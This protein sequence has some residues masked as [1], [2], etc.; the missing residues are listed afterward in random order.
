MQKNSLNLKEIFKKGLSFSIA[1]ALSAAAT[2]LNLAKTANADVPTITAATV[3]SVYVEGEKPSYV[4]VKVGASDAKSGNCHVYGSGVSTDTTDVAVLTTDRTSIW[5]ADDAKKEDRIEQKISVKTWDAVH[6]TTPEKEV[7]AGTTISTYLKAN[8][9]FLQNDLVGSVD[10]LTKMTTDLAG[11]DL[12]IGDAA[13]AKAATAT[14][15]DHNGKTVKIKMNGDASKIYDVCTLKVYENP[16][17]LR[18]DKP[19][20]L[21]WVADA[22]DSAYDFP[23]FVIE[24]KKDDKDARKIA[25]NDST[26]GNFKFAMRNVGETTTKL[27]TFTALPTFEKKSKEFKIQYTDP[28]TGAVLTSSDEQLLHYWYVET[29]SITDIDPAKIT[30][31]MSDNFKYSVVDLA[32]NSDV[33]KK[34]KSTLKSGAEIIYAN[35]ISALSGI[36]SG[37]ATVGLKVGKE[38]KNQQVTVTKLANDD[39]G[40]MSNFVKTV[41]SDGF[42]TIKT[43]D[44]GH[45][46][47]SLGVNAVAEESKEDNKQA[48]E[49]KSAEEAKKAEE[50]KKAEENKSA[51]SSKSASSSSKSASSSAKTGDNSIVMFSA[52]GFV[53]LI[54]AL[55]LFMMKKN[56]KSF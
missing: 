52:F 40:K 4:G 13:L 6:P 30:A 23:D 38:Y 12:M 47:V 41:D 34:I 56:R 45:F 2:S 55:A 18:V 24:I 29:K 37:K 20:G 27:A 7:A 48:E 33:Y 22:G 46:V 51:D 11:Y 1:L 21:S 49:N 43:D 3:R 50:T 54:S 8:G 25:Y 44:L 19:S 26:K 28:V 14:V 32:E 53:A 39:S 36:I 15:A 16:T 17:T 35:T 31:N 42:V 9:F 5:Y 10:A